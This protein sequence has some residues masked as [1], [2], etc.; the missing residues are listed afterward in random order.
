MKRLLRQFLALPRFAGLGLVWIYQHTLSPDHGPL[1][2]LFPYGV[3][4]QHPTCSEY[5]K[6]RLRRDGLI[7]GGVAAVRRILSCHPWKTPD[8]KRLL[9]L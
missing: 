1:S 3:C 6:E 7:R 9:E 2:V 5:A 8:P 4:P